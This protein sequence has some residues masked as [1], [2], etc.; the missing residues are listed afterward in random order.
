MN[1]EQ[2][3]IQSLEADA[4]RINDEE[5]KKETPNFYE[6]IIRTTL[7]PDMLSSALLFIYIII[8]GLLS[9][10]QIFWAALVTIPIL[11]ISKLLFSPLI[12]RLI[13]S[14][15]NEKILTWQS[16]GMDS[17]G[18]RT[19]LFEDIMAFPKIKAIESLIFILA[20]H[21]LICISMHLIPAIGFSWTS[22]LHVF[23]AGL[24]QCYIV[25]L[26][27]YSQTL[28][29]CEKYA[30]ELE[31]LG[32]DNRYIRKKR[33]FGM[34]LLAKTVLF[35]ILPSL[36][37]NIT[38]CAIL[39]QG[40]S[41]VNGMI[42]NFRQQIFRISVTVA[43]NIVISLIVCFIFYSHISESNDTLTNTLTKI[44]T[45]GETGSISK[46]AIGDKMQ[47]NIYLLN[48]IVERFKR[49][50]STANKI[51][52]NI[53]ET[54][55]NLS[56]TAKQ[57]SSASLAQSASIKE[58]LATMEDSNSLSQS[59]SKNIETVTSGAEGTVQDVN[60]SMNVLS[61]IIEQ[62][63]QID[64]ANNS[65]MSVMKQLGTQIENIGDVVAI[66][67]DIADQTRIIAFNA[68]LEAVSAGD[69][70]HNFHIVATEIRRLANSTVNSIN[71]I[72]SYIQ[73]IQKSFAN[74]IESSETGTG[75]IQEET[76]LAEDLE[77]QFS[78]IKDLADVTSLK[79]NEISEIIDEQT[80]S[81]NQIVITIRQISSGIESFASLTQTI[82]KAALEM[83]TVTE[84]LSTLQ[85][86]SL[87]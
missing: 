78:V 86:D 87:M 33:L 42:L 76:V 51:G 73:N 40:N 23:I 29:I 81:F 62:M 35:I 46:T 26:I 27:S 8:C 65:I 50:F 16:G 70:G 32:L 18:D 52:M 9:P 60:S 39:F 64:A 66:I 47:Y 69:E 53:R 2:T 83:Q 17:T 20:I 67:N 80:Q 75:C 38:Y 55:N 72:N 1:T 45:E 85:R 28:K 30:E 14:D 63:K 37:A 71:E 79:S 7:I 11:I 43:M 4:D 68:E 19:A 22:T 25:S 57:L 5:E 84:K 34:G 59:I 41:E 74:L 36:I 24:F 49:M 12:N 48:S 3:N 56:V 21:S 10:S 31:M 6:E 13:A 61:E 44:I 77:S 15:I 82:S 58:I 54:S